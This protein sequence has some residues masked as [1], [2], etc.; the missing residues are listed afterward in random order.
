MKNQRSQEAKCHPLCSSLHLSPHP[1]Q[2][3]KDSSSSPTGAPP[4]TRHGAHCWAGPHDGATTPFSSPLSHHIHHT[5]WLINLSPLTSLLFVQPATQPDQQHLHIWL[6]IWGSI[7]VISHNPMWLINLSPLTSLLFVQPATQ[8]DQQHLHIWL[9]IWGSIHVISHRCFLCCRLCFFCIELMQGCFCQT[10]HLYYITG[11][12]VWAQWFIDLFLA[13][14]QSRSSGGS[15][16]YCCNNLQ[17]NAG[18]D[19]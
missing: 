5:M 11:G 9:A 17:N 2:H 13:L 8:P 10:I 15:S 4:G 14:C 12:G 16:V 6:A 3:Q 18:I 19:R 1:P 7:H